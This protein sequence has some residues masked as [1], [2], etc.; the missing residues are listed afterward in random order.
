MNTGIDAMVIGK[1]VLTEKPSAVDFEAGMKRSVALE[2]G[3]VIAS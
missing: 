2:A 1:Y 3:E